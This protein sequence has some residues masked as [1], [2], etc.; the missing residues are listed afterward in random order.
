MRTPII[1]I[2]AL[3]LIAA[4][5]VAGCDSNG[6]DMR[7]QLEELERCNRADS[8][9]TN[10]SL[11]L[12]LTNYFDRHGTP[13]E[14]MRAYY[15]LGRTYFDRG[16]MPAAL[17]A[18]HAAADRADTTRADCDY[19]TLC[20]VHAQIAD[21]FYQ[22]DLFDEVLKS[23]DRSVA[24]AY[25][26]HD[27]LAA[28]RCIAQKAT[29]YKH[30]QQKDSAIIVSLLAAR[31]CAHYGYKDF[32]AAMLGY[33]ACL[34][35]EEG[36][37]NKVAGYM[38]TYEKESGFFKSGLNIKPG[39][40]AYYYAKGLYYMQTHK[41]DSAE[42][43]FRKELKDG[44]DFN[45]QNLGSSGLAQL[46]Q[47]KQLPDSSAKYALY[48]YAMNDS[49]HMKKVTESVERLQAIYIYE[50]Y[51]QEALEK[52]RQA[53]KKENIIRMLWLLL[54]IIIALFAL[55]VHRFLKK[56]K[57][58]TETYAKQVVLLNQMKSERDILMNH[59]FE[60][61]K[62]IA[63]KTKAI[64]DLTVK[65]EEYESK[66]MKKMLIQNKIE[67]D[68]FRSDEYKLFYSYSICGKEPH[69]EDWDKLLIV[70]DSKL[71][72]FSQFLSTIKG[73]LSEVEYKVCVLA[74]LKIKPKS[75]ACMLNVT[76]AYISKCRVVLLKKIYHKNGKGCLFDQEICRLC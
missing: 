65:I 28:L 22:Q 34:Q 7:A 39:M 72:E 15:I 56:K 30:T 38:D 3:L 27:T 41:L 5:M 52:S 46:F 16:E 9:M 37:T 1:Y 75:I 67:A 47:K 73:T 19:R 68:M 59:Q 23:I 57:I 55:I 14:Q 45:N 43:F 74:R 32:S 17:E 66:S 11:A 2:G 50:H 61:Q 69:D 20:R 10:D 51:K 54:A 8:L 58:I 33:A 31:Q 44:K 48:S 12:V 36:D 21:L 4:T 40:E 35:L 6:A 13:N 63:E 64:E 76:P 29:V 53:Q 70:I 49:M 18:Y 25:R 71:P 42:F 62:Q 24:C 26:S 60:F